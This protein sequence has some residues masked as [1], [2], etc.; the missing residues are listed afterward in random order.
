MSAFG[1][2]Q[3]SKHHTCDPTPGNTAPDPKQHLSLDPKSR[4]VDVY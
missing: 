3:H 2:M 4:R 1:R